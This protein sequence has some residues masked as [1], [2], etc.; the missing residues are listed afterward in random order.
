MKKLLKQINKKTFIILFFL[1]FFA[2]LSLF[3]FDWPQE[4]A[5]LKEIRNFFAENRN[6][7][8]SSSL[9]FPKGELVTLSETGKLLFRYE[10]KKSCQA[11]PSSLGNALVF[12]HE[13][14]L[15]TVYANLDRIVIDDSNDFV[16]KG[17]EIALSG[18]S[19][20]HKTDSGLEFAVIDVKN[21]AVINPLLVLPMNHTALDF[22]VGKIFLKDSNGE[23][24]ELSNSK[25]FKEG[26]YRFYRDAKDLMPLYKT[27]I[28]ING[29]TVDT[30]TKDSLYLW[31]ERLVFKSNK[32][33]RLSFSKFFPIDNKQYLCEVKLS[34]GKNTI[35]VEAFD[36]LANKKQ[37]QYSLDI[38]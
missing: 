26:T 35:I 25:S 23:Y 22:Q 4:I 30:L 2:S 5:S 20:W 38:Y 36:I 3:A 32:G 33:E 8:I 6:T 17:S 19:A 13:N 21:K 16:Q 24:R 15:R 1:I 10:E 14:D 28:S 27:I 18:D 12:A 37:V 7:S 9:I 31:E 11:F 34:R 29:K